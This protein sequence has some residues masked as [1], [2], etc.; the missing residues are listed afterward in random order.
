MKNGTTDIDYSATLRR[1]TVCPIGC[2]A[3]RT[4]E[5]GACGAC[6]EIEVS[7]Y[8]LHFGEEPAVSGSRG[9]GTVFFTHCPLRCIFCQNYPIS[10]LGHGRPFSEEGF[11]NLM[12]G[13]QGEG[14]H[15][16][17]FVTPTHYTPQLISALKKIKGTRLT[18]PT[19]YNCSGYERV[20]TLRKL[21]G[22]IDIYMPDSK[23]SENG[24]AGAVCR[25][26]DY[27][28]VNRAALLEMRRQV[29]DLKLNKDG[30]AVR[31]VIV[32]HLVLPG[33]LSGTLDV[34]R[35]ISRK[36]GRKTHISLMAQ[37]HPASD[38]AGHRILGRRITENEYAEAVREAE[39]LGFENCLTQSS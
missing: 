12:L 31:G 26:K 15:N 28:E 20:E 21:Q 4:R 2:G 7:S 38:A 13:L 39:M 35:F 9:S 23:F 8:N 24:S 36:M 10:H 18:I 30:V 5:R 29:G 37:Y 1:C 16:I 19:I 33:G 27:T 11:I 25:A 34:L 3:D 6:D 17:N 14:A 32:R 22:L